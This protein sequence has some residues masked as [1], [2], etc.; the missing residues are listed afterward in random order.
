MK[1]LILLLAICATSFSVFAQKEKKKISIGIMDF[2]IPSASE[3]RDAGGFFSDPNSA[4]MLK[5]R[6]ESLQSIVTEFYTKDNRFTVVDRRATEALSK[7]RELQKSEDFMDGYV[8]SQGKSIGAEYL[9]RGNY[10]IRTS[11]LVLTLYSMEEAKMIAKESD[12]LKNGFFGTKDL[13]G[14]TED[15]VRRL[16]NTAFPLLIKVVEIK[17]QSKSKVKSVLIAGGINRGLKSYMLLDIKVKQEIEV[18]GE[19]QV[20][21][22]TIG[23][24]E[25]D[26]VEDLNFAIVKVNEGG[27]EV[28]K[29][30][31]AGTK[32]YCTFQ[33][34]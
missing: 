29:C 10:E 5:P 8:V 7:E 12:V 25:V 4:A 22:K 32:L 34:K 20:Y 28:K 31:D 27:E 19:K 9:L 23:I 15:I 6:I 30:L 26:K 13:V 14:P 3:I 18:E 16:N 33:N 21:Y 1:K 24:A 17:E 11:R 2:A